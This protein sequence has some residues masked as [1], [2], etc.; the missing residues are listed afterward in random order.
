MTLLGSARR[1]APQALL[2]LVSSLLVLAAAEIALRRA[3]PVSLVTIGHRFSANAVRY[4]WGFD[5]YETV[6]TSD[7][8]TGEVYVDRLNGAGWRDRDHA[9]GRAPGVFRILVLGDSVTYGPIVGLDALYT[10]RAEALL[11]KRGYSA[12]VISIAYARWG[13]D[14]ELEALRLEG[15]AYAPDLVV[16]EFT[17]NDPFDNLEPME[18]G[19]KPFRY[20]LDPKGTLVRRSNPWFLQQHREDLKALAW[21]RLRD[22]FEVLKRLALL[23][24]RLEGKGRPKAA[25]APGHGVPLDYVVGQWGLNMLSQEFGIDPK[26][27]VATWLR[28]RRGQRID[29]R[30]LRALLSRTPQ[31]ER[32]EEVL[33]TFEKRWF[34]ENYKTQFGGSLGVAA[35]V[36]RLQLALYDEMLRLTRLAGARFL[37]FSTHEG[38]HFAWDRYWFHVAKGPGVREGY[39]S[40]NDPLRDWARSRGVDFLLP[41]RPVVRARNDP[42]PNQEGNKVLAHAL[43]HYVE[44]RYG[45]VMPRR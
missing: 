42:H 13:T 39:L 26:G 25:P 31:A 22:R 34:Q 37:L 11:R 18:S 3:A 23:V 41:D 10:R 43:A 1:A 15:L 14:Q 24:R 44:S 38:G 6:V 17:A 36:M 9:P 40:L 35:N 20:E 30:E 27:E 4:G 21:R 28:A 5:P 12:E 29:P 8:D 33:R 45:A 19:L 2:V 32:T 7:P 16:V